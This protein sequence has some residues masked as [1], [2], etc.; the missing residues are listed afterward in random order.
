M[1]GYD[2]KKIM[3]D[4]SFMYWSGNNNQIYKALVDLLD[5]GYVINEVQHQDGA[6]S[7][8]I[9]T[10]TDRGRSALRDFAQQQP[11][12]PEIKKP[13][14]IQLAWAAQ[15]SNDQIRALLDGYERAI[16][17]QIAMAK[18]KSEKPRF[19]PARSPREAALWRAI[20][21][22]VIL[23][24]ES[25]LRWIENLRTQLLDLPDDG[26]PQADAA[27]TTDD[28]PFHYFLVDRD[29]GCYLMLDAFGAPIDSERAAVDLVALCLEYGCNSILLPG[30]R[31][32]DD[33]LRLRT[34]IAGRVLGKFANYRIRVACVMSNDRIKGKFEDFALESNRG[35]VFRIYETIED[36]EP[37]LLQ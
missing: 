9:Y 37:W 8:K 20:D 2:L 21:D 29:H 18:F 30:E 24:Y 3:Q 22:S 5:K 36:A 14:L 16:T 26:S 19:A 27:T 34:G 23:S 31:I 10:I 7:K 11:E 15:L 1:T 33:F 6:P 28:E 4:S 17:E 12:P 35:N 13:F 25:E 32:T